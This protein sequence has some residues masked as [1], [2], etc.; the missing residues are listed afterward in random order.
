MTHITPAH[1]TIEGIANQPGKIGDIKIGAVRARG[2]VQM[3]VHGRAAGAIVEIDPADI[4]AM[5]AAL[6]AAAKAAV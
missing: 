1:V 2:T 3:M 6:R 5:I 4:P